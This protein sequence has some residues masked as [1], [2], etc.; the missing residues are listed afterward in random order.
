MDRVKYIYCDS[1]VFLAYFKGEKGR[2]EK[3]ESLI[4]QVRGEKEL[5]LLS[6]LL[7]VTEV[8]HTATVH[9]HSDS[10][11]ETIETLD[12]FWGN[13]SIVELSDFHIVLAKRA[14]ALVRGHRGLDPRDAIHLA[15]ALQSKA[16]ELLTYDNDLLKIN[17]YYEM[18]ICEPHL[19][20]HR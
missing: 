1:N 20:R 11:L 19:R 7:S 18:E 16:S 15:T 5:S 14:R 6:S 4:D 12:N 3:V 9:S 8:A 10:E 13:S 17:D 2:A